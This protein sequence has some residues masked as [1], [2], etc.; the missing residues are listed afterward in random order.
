MIKP[1]LAHKV[2]QTKID[3]SKPVFMQPKLDGVRC[4]IALED[5]QVIAR[6]RTGKQ[7]LISSTLPSLYKNSL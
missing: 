5:N 2:D 3:Y 4:V 6:S 7:W 1:M